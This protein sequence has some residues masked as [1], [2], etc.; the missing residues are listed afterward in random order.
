M[1]VLQANTG[2]RMVAAYD[3]LLGKKWI[4][5]FDPFDSGG[6]FHDMALD[7]MNSDSRGMAVSGDTV[8]YGKTINNVHYLCAQRVYNDGFVLLDTIKL[9]L[10]FFGLFDDEIH[11]ISI[12]NGIIAVAYGAQFAW[13]TW[14]GG[15]LSELAMDFKFD[16]RTMGVELKNNYLYVADRFFGLKI[17]DI[18][19]MNSA[20]L[21]AQC[22]G[23]GG[24]KNLYGNGTVTV[25]P[26]GT[27]YLTDFH[28]GVI[29]IEPFDHT[30]GTAEA[31]KPVPDDKSLNVFPN[32]AAGAINVEFTADDKGRAEIEIFDLN[33]KKVLFTR[34]MKCTKGKNMKTIDIA[35]LSDAHYVLVLKHGLKTYS[36]I[37]EVVK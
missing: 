28:A 29:M 30:L 8:Y 5:L 9:S 22:R 33:G 10:G 13:Y 20:V 24:W 26:D 35:D 27:I 16:Q 31:G 11:S 4:T 21:V 15:V 14:D 3:N 25:G 34:E 7:S 17:Y 2:T 12:D 1:S 23:T 37:F 6:N 19:S 36:K 18:S 32:P